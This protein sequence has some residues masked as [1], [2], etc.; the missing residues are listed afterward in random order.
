METT[1]PLWQ[2][3]VAVLIAF[4]FWLWAVL[5]WLRLTRAHQSIHGTSFVAELTQ[6]VESVRAE[7]SA[8][9][10]LLL[11]A[12]GVFLKVC[13]VAGLLVERSITTSLIAA[14]P[15]GIAAVGSVCAPPDWIPAAIHELRKLLE[16]LGRMRMT[17][18]K[19]KL[20]SSVWVCR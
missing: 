6:W 9:G 11:V 1:T 7:R 16:S 2:C 3:L 4:T 17:P 13:N 10:R 18:A 12:G 5:Y 19:C 15:V 14:G 8:L 20:I